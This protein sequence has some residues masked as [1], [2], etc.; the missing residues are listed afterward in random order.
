MTTFRAA[1]VAAAL[2]I[3]ASQ[4]SASSVDIKLLNILLANGSITPAQHEELMADLAREAHL[5]AAKEPPPQPDQQ[6]FV[7]YEKLAG[8]AARTTLRGDVRVRQDYID[9]EDEPKYATA[10]PG[11]VLPSVRDRNRQRLRARLGAFTQVNPEVATGFRLASGNTA[12]RRSSNQDLDNFFTKKAI[13]LDLAY[14]DYRPTQAPGLTLLAGKINQP[15]MSLSEVVWDGDINPEGIAAQY[16]YETRAATLF[17]SA[18]YYVLKDNIDGN[19]KDLAM[20]ALQGGWAFNPADFMRLTLGASHYAFSNDGRRTS[21]N[22]PLL[23][24]AAN[25]NTTD[26]FG[27]YELFGQMDVTGLPVPLSIYGQY[28]VNADADDYFDG[29]TLYT[30]ADEDTA[31]LLGIRTNLAGVA[32]NYSY[33]DVERNAVIGYFTESDFAAGYVGSRG[34]SLRAQYEILKNFSVTVSWMPAKS[35]VA[36]RYNDDASVETLMIDLGARF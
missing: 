7:A 8:W 23:E 3:A 14:I 6:D 13:W 22:G 33:R 17:G 25:G 10:P 28:I 5:A 4:S 27:L 18:S 15:W 26:K 20:Y 9:I 34:H 1:F 30:D 36:S 12:D 35:K 21:F 2:L 19:G 16:S 31:W 11:S 29:T 24:M 32:L